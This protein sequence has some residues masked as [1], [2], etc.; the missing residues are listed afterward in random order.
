MAKNLGYGE[1]NNKD[2]KNP[3]AT[4]VTEIVI[5]D[6]RAIRDLSQGVVQ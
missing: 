5:V 2:K 4:R 3:T 6:G 1:D